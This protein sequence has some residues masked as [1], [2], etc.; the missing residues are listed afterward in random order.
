VDL[1]PQKEG[2][3]F[4]EESHNKDR[5]KFIGGSDI[6]SIM[7]TSPYKTAYTLWLEK[8]GKKPP[9]DI[10]GEFHVQRGVINEPV[11][12]AKLEEQLGEKFESNKRFVENYKSCEVD[13][14]SNTTIVE[15]K[16]MGAKAHEAVK[17]GIVPKGYIDQCQWNMLLSKTN[18]CIFASYRPEDDS[19]HLYSI[20][21][22]EKRQIK[23]FFKVDEFWHGNVL[24]DVEPPLTDADYKDM[25]SDEEFKQL[26]KAFKD[27]SARK[28]EAEET[29]SAIK[30]DLDKLLKSKDITKGMGHGLRLNKYQ[31]KGSVEY[32]KIPELE[33]VNLEEYRKKPVNVFDVRAS[34]PR[35][36]IIG[37]HHMD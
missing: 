10:S 3:M 30:K 11:A 29:L 31:R 12:L 25:S 5:T 19:L 6:A 22:D 34:K 16:C 23:I 33:G 37:E 20:D 32:K 14:Y 2:T 36:I 13:G 8:T 9:V 18:R 7:G 4:L 28:K 15:I 26:A 24:A 35:E 17:D 1:G 21:R 27:V